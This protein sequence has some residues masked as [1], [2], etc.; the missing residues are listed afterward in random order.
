MRKPPTSSTTSWRRSRLRL[1]EVAC[2]RISACSAQSA[3]LRHH[4]P[5]EFLCSP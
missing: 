1:P 3:W 2:G 5:A 4:Y